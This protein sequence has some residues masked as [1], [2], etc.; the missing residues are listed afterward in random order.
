[1]QS[2]FDPS[3]SVHFDLARG[4][5]ALDAADT[6]LLVPTAA[7]SALCRSAG[8]EAVRDFGRLIGT[9]AGRR[10]ADR[11]GRELDTASVEVVLD[12]LGG[13]L[14]LL[15][16]GSLGIERWGRALVLTVDGS[17]F[18]AEGDPLVASVLEGALQ[19]ALVRSVSVVPLQRDDQRVRMLVANAGAAASVRSWLAESVTWGE[20]LTKLNARGAAQA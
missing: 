9:E 3:Q 11:L 6:R 17:P 12:H 10:V 20:V 7:L 16:F 8:L 4:R 15:G 2:R 1:M 13:D 19:R 18:G 14:A 5:V